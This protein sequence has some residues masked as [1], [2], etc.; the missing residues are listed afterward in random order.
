MIKKKSKKKWKLE[1]ISYIFNYS[2]KYEE[3]DENI[4]EQYIQLQNS[5]CEKQNESLIQ[6]YENKIIKADAIYFGKQFEMFVYKGSDTVSKIIRSSHKWEDSFTLNVLK[7]LEYYSKKKNLE[8]KDIYLL[9][10][11]SNIGWYAYYLGKYGY[12]ILSF[13]ANKINNY[14]LYKN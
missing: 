8:N 3:F 14:I 4:N 7:A 9:D 12:K 2:L 13:E 11:V 6:E 5:F 1:N 10:I